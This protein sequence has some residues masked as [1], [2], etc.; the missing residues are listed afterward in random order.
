MPICEITSFPSGVNFTSPDV[1]WDSRPLR[2]STVSFPPWHPWISH[3]TS[4]CACQ[5]AAK[6]AAAL[7]CPPRLLLWL[8]LCHSQHMS[9]TIKTLFSF[10]FFSFPLH[11]HWRKYRTAIRFSIIPRPWMAFGGGLHCVAKGRQHVS[12]NLSKPY[13]Y[14][15]CWLN[16]KGNI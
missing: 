9:T 2:L 10:L 5:A 7:L 16:H 12:N 3:I 15:W 14:V 11:F 1:L 8:W 13:P 6:L 4:Y